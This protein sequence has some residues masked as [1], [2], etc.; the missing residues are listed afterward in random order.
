MAIVSY[1][2]N[3]ASVQDVRKRPFSFGVVTLSPFD[4]LPALK[5]ED[6]SVGNP[7]PRFISVTCRGRS[8]SDRSGH[9]PAPL[10]GGVDL[11]GIV[12]DRCSGIV[13]LADA[14]LEPCRERAWQRLSGPAGPERLTSG[15]PGP[16]QSPVYPGSQI[17]TPVRV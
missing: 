2:K 14:G 16:W 8:L 6:F 9:G 11:G 5:R 15:R 13:G 3:R 1:L 4:L 17:R 10:P 12:L 7:A